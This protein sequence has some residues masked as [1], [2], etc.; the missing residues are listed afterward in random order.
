MVILTTGYSSTGRLE[1]E[2]P[3][4][5]AGR[6]LGNGGVVLHHGLVEYANCLL[7]LHRMFLPTDLPHGQAHGNSSGCSRT[8]I[9]SR[10]Q[11]CG[12]R[13]VGQQLL[14]GRSPCRAQHLTGSRQRRHRIA[15]QR[16]GARYGQRGTELR[17]GALQR[18]QLLRPGIGQQAAAL[19][20]LRRPELA[21]QGHQ[22]HHV[23][24]KTAER[25]HD[26]RAQAHQTVV[27]PQGPE[28]KDGKSNPEK[29][30]RPQHAQLPEQ[31]RLHPS[32]PEKQKIETNDGR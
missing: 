21:E 16:A 13:R 10:G 22:P 11:R 12:L 26:S 20:G 31:V 1:A 23:R 19:Y 3:G 18:S 6:K 7:V 29:G 14:Q 28:Q 32:R 5:Q 27:G 4:Q 17:H 24:V 30:R 25:L 2:H 8:S 9:D 15:L